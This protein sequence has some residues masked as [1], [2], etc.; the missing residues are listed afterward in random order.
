MAA[1]AAIGSRQWNRREAGTDSESSSKSDARVTSGVT[2]ASV[3]DWRQRTCR[4]RFSRSGRRRQRT[5]R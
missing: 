5:R 4:Q 3:F 2:S 1:A